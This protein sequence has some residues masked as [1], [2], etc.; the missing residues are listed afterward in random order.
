[1]MDET[2]YRKLYGYD[3]ITDLPDGPRQEGIMRSSKVAPMD[4]E[5]VPKIKSSLATQSFPD[6][7]EKTLGLSRKNS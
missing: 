2:T 3:L 6:D 5:L 7:D 1:M 4:D